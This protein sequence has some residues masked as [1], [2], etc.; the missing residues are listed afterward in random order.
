MRLH[1]DLYFTGTAGKEDFVI[2]CEKGTG[3][4]RIKFQN[5]DIKKFSL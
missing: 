1:N 5:K 3:S 2:F 4:F